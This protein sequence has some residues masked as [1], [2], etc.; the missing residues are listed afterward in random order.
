M[1][2]NDI[3]TKRAA[4]I[5]FLGI[6]A[7][8]LIWYFQIKPQS[9]NLSELKATTTR[10]QEE[11]NKILVLR[12]QLEKMRVD[13]ANLQKEMDSL[14]AIFPINPDVP[15]L[16]TSITKVAREQYIAIT[17]FRPTGTVAKEFYVE[18]HYEMS[19]LGSYHNIG[20]FFARIANFDL[21]VNIDR[22]NVRVGSTLTTDLQ[23]FERYGG[24]RS[25]DKMIRSVQVSFR[26]TTYSS[27]RGDG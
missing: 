15:G 24:D 14:E 23:N 22:T 1:D 12:P 9:G 11:L 16:I 13:V 8:G 21:L 20:S 25:A 17:N 7:A 2:F 6:V 3:K 4:V 27:L 5:I 26:I 18:N 19:V 10:K